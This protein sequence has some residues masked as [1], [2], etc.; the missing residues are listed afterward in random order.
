MRPHLFLSSC[1]LAVLVPV[2]AGAAAVDGR[3]IVER[4]NGRGANA[5]ATC[6][7]ANGIGLAGAVFVRLAGLNEAY[8]AKQL[9]DFKQ[10]TRDNPVMK[11]MAA[12]LNDA[13]IAAVARY[14]ASQPAPKVPAEQPAAAALIARGEA[15]ARDGVWEKDVPACF[16]CH[17]PNGKGVPPHFPAIAG[18]PS[19]YIVEQLDAWRAGRRNNDPVGLM[20]AVAERLS[21]DDIKAVSVFLA[22]FSATPHAGDKPWTAR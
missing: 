1:L 11:P 15:L 19:G 6:H 3:A 17:G 13:E 16:Q 9:H 4:G 12:A 7:G 14:Y 22:S 2:A 10:G 20:K 8:I 21:A 5:C 18:Q